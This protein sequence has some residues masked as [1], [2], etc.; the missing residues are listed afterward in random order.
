[1]GVQHQG[2]VQIRESLDEEAAW[3]W[4]HPRQHDQ[5][6]LPL[7]RSALNPRRSSNREEDG[8][9]H[10]EPVLQVERLIL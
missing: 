6:D 4:D 10:S 7:P 9:V 1:M 2:P 3:G 8:S 5:E